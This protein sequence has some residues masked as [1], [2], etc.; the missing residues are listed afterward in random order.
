M[1]YDQY[2]GHCGKLYGAWWYTDCHNSNL[3][4][5]NY[6]KRNTT[7]YAKGISWLNT[8]N[9]PEQGHYFSW[10]IAVMKI[11]KSGMV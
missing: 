9:V 10:P 1:T 7:V 2:D 3:N 6:N 5:M 11:R 8:N 4:G